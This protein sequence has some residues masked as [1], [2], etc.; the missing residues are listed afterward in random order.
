MELYSINYSHQLNLASGIFG[1]NNHGVSCPK[2]N[3]CNK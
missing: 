2:S 3:F 1:P